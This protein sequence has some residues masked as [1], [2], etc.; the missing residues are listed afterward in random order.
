MADR[1]QPRNR[2]V[3]KPRIRQ[4]L[5]A[6]NPELDP[7]TN[8]AVGGRQL[9]GE[10]DD[11][12]A[13]V[14]ALRAVSDDLT[15]NHFRY[16]GT[17]DSNYRFNAA[18]TGTDDGDLIVK[19]NSIAAEDPGRWGKESASSFHDDTMG[20]SGGG[21]GDRQHLTHQQ[22]ALVDAVPNKADQSSLTTHTEDEGNPHGVTAGQAGADPVGSA[23]GVQSNLGTHE[24]LGNPHSSSASTGQL[25]G[26][27]GDEG[28]PHQVGYAQT[29]ADQAGAAAAVQSNLTT[30]ENDAANPHATSNDHGG[31]SGR[32]TPSQHPASAI[33][34]DASGFGGILS[35]TDV[36]PQIAL[37][38]ID[39]MSSGASGPDDWG[40]D[41][42]FVL[43]EGADLR[44]SDVPDLEVQTG[45][46]RLWNKSTNA[47]FRNPKDV[48]LTVTAAN[49]GKQKVANVEIP[50][51]V[52][53]VPIIHDGAEADVAGTFD[54]IRVNAVATS[55]VPKY[56]GRYVAI[57]LT[58]TSGAARDLSSIAY[59][60]KVIAGTLVVKV[61]VAPDN[62]ADA[63]NWASKTLIG[64]S[65]S[66]GAVEADYTLTL[67]G[68][69][70]ASTP[71][72][73][74]MDMNFSNNIDN[75]VK[76]VTDGAVLTDLA[77]DLWF[78]KSTD[79]TTWANQGTTTYSMG[80][81]A[82]N[83]W[84]GENTQGMTSLAAA[85]VPAFPAVTADHKIIGTIGDPAG[86]TITNTTDEVVDSSPGG[87]SVLLTPAADQ[88][89][90]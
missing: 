26:H 43:M 22:V 64:T 46:H 27:T 34:V 65:P 58:D 2:P 74:I 76:I 6:A 3:L 68:V 10:K 33:D 24:G 20:I 16:V 19:P 17:E 70:P 85:G 57:R 66:H 73:V 1:D 62:G 9:V 69:L 23:A 50:I 49:V 32:A 82:R 29:G 61:Y 77:N 86:V 38:T 59:R 44:A 42:D 56:A 30:H 48:A 21:D 45:R 31:L 72:W 39:A 63:P 55:W 15:Q 35:S 89:R 78:K 11:P 7:V 4:A 12:V 67:N 52:D 83:S 41:P 75:W 37:E 84:F 87:N 90:P 71:T 5:D 79:G 28:N 51:T 40:T 81:G 88:Y 54:V 80:D 25:I 13:D 18:S 14:A 47:Y 60:Y 53:G 8:P 36:T